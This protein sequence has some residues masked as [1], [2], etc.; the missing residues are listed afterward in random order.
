M[1]EKLQREALAFPDK[2]INTFT[3]NVPFLALIGA[4]ETFLAWL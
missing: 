3:R 4:P 1:G 2:R